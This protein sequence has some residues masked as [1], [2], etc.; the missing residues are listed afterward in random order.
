MKDC[1]SDILPTTTDPEKS[2]AL[3]SDMEAGHKVTNY[4]LRKL[5]RDIRVSGGSP[6]HE[7]RN[8]TDFDVAR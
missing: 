5:R 3:R 4:E 8:F 7:S 2:S 6:L 1:A